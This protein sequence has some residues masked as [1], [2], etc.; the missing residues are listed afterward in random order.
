MLEEEEEARRAAQA[1][2]S[3]QIEQRMIEKDIQDNIARQRAMSMPEAS[4]PGKKKKKQRDDSSESSEG[5]LDKMGS[6]FKG[7][8]AAMKKSL[9]KKDE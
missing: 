8:V 7:K 3:R 1:Q 6:F 4:S 9:A 5:V 2:R